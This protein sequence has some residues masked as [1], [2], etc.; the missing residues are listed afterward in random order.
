MGLIFDK[1]ASDDDAEAFMAT[2]REKF[3]DHR[4]YGPYE[5]QEALAGPSRE[6]AGRAGQPGWGDGTVQD[7]GLASEAHDITIVA[8]TPPIVLVTRLDTP[9]LDPAEDEIA[10][11]AATFGAE[12]AGT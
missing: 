7:G 1:F 2:V 11:V 5:S 3:P 8:L 12:F 4:A 6:L 10:L 9:E